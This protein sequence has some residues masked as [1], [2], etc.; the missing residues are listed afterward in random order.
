MSTTDVRPGAGT[1]AVG[2]VSSGELLEAIRASHLEHRIIQMRQLDMIE[3][4]CLMAAGGALGTMAVVCFGS[5]NVFLELS[6]GVAFLVGAVCGIQGV[7]QQ[8]WPRSSK[9]AKRLR[10]LESDRNMTSPPPLKQ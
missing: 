1:Q 9:E 6:G 5:G 7:V 4:A 8:V 2:K 3:A 10:Q